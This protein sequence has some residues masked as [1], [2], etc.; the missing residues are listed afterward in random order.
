[1][2]GPTVREVMDLYV[3]DR[4]G[5]VANPATLRCIVKPVVRI[6]GHL[7]TASIDQDAVDAFIATRTA[8]GAAGGTIRRDLSTLLAARRLA[9]RRKLIPAPEDVTIPRAGPSR[10]RVLTEE[11]VQRLLAAATDPRCRLLIHIGLCTGA[12]LTA[13]AELTWDRVNLDQGVIDFNAPHPRAARRKGRAIVPI[14]TQLAEI[15][16]V[17]RPVSGQGPVLGLGAA[18][19]RR[20]F[21]LARDA[22][23]LGRD[24]TPHVMRHTAASV[25]IRS[26]PLIEA[27]RMLGH[28]NTAITESVYVHMT[29]KDLRAAAEAAAGVLPVAV[30]ATDQLQPPG[31]V[32]RL[33][34]VITALAGRQ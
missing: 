4:D 21:E 25:M 23:G 18:A 28:R 5:V 30:E 14:P 17:L 9:H 19:L 2:T 24:V 8:E 26:V 12:R 27:S 29:A 33:W 22:A 32:R 10:K 3:T 7:D 1:M 34:R 6:L 13:M 11:E 31:P 20:H 16:A 15:L